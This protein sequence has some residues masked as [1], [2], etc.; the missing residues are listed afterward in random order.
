L[1]SAQNLER[2]WK[3][4]QPMGLAWDLAGAN[5]SDWNLV[6]GLRSQPKVA[7]LPFILFF[8]E[9]GQISGGLTNILFKPLNSKSLAEYLERLQPKDIHG[10]ILIVDDD[11]HARQLY[12]RLVEQAFPG[13]AVRLAEN[14]LQALEYLQGEIPGLVI[15][16][17]VMPEVDGF[18]VLAKLRSSPVTCRVPVIVI[19]GKLLT[20]EDIEKLNY[21]RVT[22]HTK[23]ILSPEETILSLQ[24]SFYGEQGLSQPTSLLVKQSVVYLQQNYA[25]NLSRCELAQAVGVTENY[26]SQIFRQ[27]LGITPWECLNRLRIQK[28]KE[29]L[30]NSQQTIT[31]I[32]CQV[33]FND[34]AYF[35]RVFK[36][37]MGVSPQA[38]R[39]HPPDA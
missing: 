24:G 18:Q 34:P 21:A 1:H 5:L 7:R 6:Q 13:H 31:E 36:K 14:G 12:Q 37:M 27:E 16:D 39:S 30:L 29:T 15:L 9:C 10:S 35:S 23:E 38:Y 19:S 17:L 33:G 8:Q 3:D 26:L 2:L 25:N 22:L 28:A 11:A 4:I 20:F 32:A